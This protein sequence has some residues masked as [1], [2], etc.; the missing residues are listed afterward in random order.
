MIF[1]KTHVS[2]CRGKQ[3]PLL[4]FAYLPHDRGDILLPAVTAEPRSCLL[5]VIRG[6]VEEQAPCCELRGADI[7]RG[8]NITGPQDGVLLSASHP[9]GS[10]RGLLAGKVPLAFHLPCH[11]ECTAASAEKEVT[12]HV[13]SRP[14][15]RVPP[16]CLSDSSFSHQKKNK[17]RKDQSS[18]FPLPAGAG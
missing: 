10:P 5:V 11:V 17:T 4:V 3:I 7:D 8:E 18:P 12:A 14:L 9:R 13:C 6:K 16:S 15:T 1:G 2:R